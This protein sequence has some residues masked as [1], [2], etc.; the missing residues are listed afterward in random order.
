M[1]ISLSF[2]SYYFLFGVFMLTNYDS[3]SRYSVSDYF[4]Y[5]M[6]SNKKGKPEVKDIIVR[7][8]RA[9]RSSKS[10][11][12]F[13]ESLGL[14][15]S[16]N[17]HKIKIKKSA[18]VC[19]TK[20]SSVVNKLTKE[21]SSTKTKSKSNVPSGKETPITEE[22]STLTTD[23]MS[24]ATTPPKMDNSIIKGQ[25]SSKHDSS[26]TNEETIELSN[27]GDK[28]PSETCDISGDFKENNPRDI[29]VVSISSSSDLE[30][31]E[32]REMFSN[33]DTNLGF[34]ISDITDEEIISSDDDSS[35]S[36]S[37]IMLDAVEESS[38]SSVKKVL[39]IDLH[40]D[41]VTNKHLAK[42]SSPPADEIVSR[43]PKS[44][45]IT[46]ISQTDPR[47]QH[48]QHNIDEPRREKDIVEVVH[49]D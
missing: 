12:P 32:F 25:R 34:D 3:C 19:D 1:F 4:Y 43:L 38:E 10:K 7:P 49:I 29:E 44:T 28:K 5:S 18:T 15:K 39:S 30:D 20:N 6:E 2:S 47:T 16:K 21:P 22:I 17:D 41:N 37:C 13:T 26:I 11:Q 14:S 48:M 46:R 8:S 35:S 24:L 45:S 40:R 42:Q 9:T 23:N 33:I 31:D 27:K 36:S